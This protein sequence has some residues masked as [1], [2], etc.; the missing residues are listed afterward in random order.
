MVLVC[1]A[2]FQDSRNKPRKATSSAVVY[3]VNVGDVVTLLR[4]AN[5]NRTYLTIR[6]E[7]IGIDMRYSYSNNPADLNSTKGFLIRFGESVDVESPQPIYSVCVVA[8]QTVDICMDEG[9]G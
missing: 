2:S 1:L 7:S 3:N 8:G 9:S 5:P 4:P 6:N